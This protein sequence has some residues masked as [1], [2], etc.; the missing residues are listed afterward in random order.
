MLIT[1]SAPLFM[2]VLI[3]CFAHHHRTKTNH[4]PQAQVEY[5]TNAYLHIS[6]IMNSKI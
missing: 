1:F 5:E 6:C 2:P 4:S 3:C